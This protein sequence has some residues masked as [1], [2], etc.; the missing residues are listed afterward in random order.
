M[1]P[2]LL[3]SLLRSVTPGEAMFVVSVSVGVEVVVD[4]VVWNVQFDC[5]VKLSSVCTF[6]KNIKLKINKLTK[7]RVVQ[8]NAKD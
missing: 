4:V 3:F 1:I 8:R 5:S 2:Q 6:W 7:D